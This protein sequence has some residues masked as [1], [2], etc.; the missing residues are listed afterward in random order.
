MSLT[1]AN[2][3]QPKQIC[4]CIQNPTEAVYGNPFSQIC[5]RKAKQTVKPHNVGCLR[6]LRWAQPCCFT[7]SLAR[8]TASGF[9]SMAKTWVSAQEAAVNRRTGAKSLPQ[10]ANFA[11]AQARHVTSWAMAAFCFLTSV[12]QQSNRFL[13]EASQKRAF[14]APARA[15]MIASRANGP[16]PISTTVAAGKEDKRRWMAAANLEVRGTSS[17]MALL[18]GVFWH[19]GATQPSAQGAYALLPGLPPIDGM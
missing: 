12:R 15:A 11:K 9:F 1:R 5:A 13:S 14:L 10:G 6:S 3:T 19:V 17:R 16:V 4:K 8:V 7:V 2:A 18:D